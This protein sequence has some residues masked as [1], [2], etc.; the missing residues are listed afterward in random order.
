MEEEHEYANELLK[1]GVKNPR[2]VP[3]F[4]IIHERFSHAKLKYRRPHNSA[5]LK[6]TVMLRPDTMYYKSRG[7]SYPIKNVRQHNLAEF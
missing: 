1:Q 3:K 2:K 6:N 5:N 4:T 7:F